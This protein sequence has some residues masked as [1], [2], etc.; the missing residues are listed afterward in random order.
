MI[1]PAAITATCEHRPSTSAITCEENTT[2]PPPAVYRPSTLRMIRADT[3]STASNGSSS[4]STRG[5]C[6]S[7]AARVIFFRMP[8]E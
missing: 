1:R 6:S 2:V 5:E 3:G 7:A 8:V 4:S